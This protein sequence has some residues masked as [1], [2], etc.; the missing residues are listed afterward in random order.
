[1]RN[2][3]VNRYLLVQMHLSARSHQEK[4]SKLAIETRALRKLKLI[5]LERLKFRK[6]RGKVRSPSLLLKRRR[7]M[8]DE[9]Q[10][11]ARRVKRSQL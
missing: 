3:V 6:R 7:V 1:M 8:V 10:A 2:Q 4:P 5:K 9:S 11:L